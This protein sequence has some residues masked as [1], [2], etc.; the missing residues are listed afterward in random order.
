M[1]INA[2][3]S[4]QTMSTPA[5]STV[6]PSAPVPEKNSVSASEKGVQVNISAQAHALAQ[7]ESSALQSKSAQIQ[8]VPL[9]EE[10]APLPEPP[11]S[12]LTGEKLEQ[13]AQ[14]KKAQAQ[15]Q[16]QAD[17]ANMMLG[18]DTSISASTAYYL[19][20][21]EDA[22]EALL[23]SNKQQNATDNMQNYQQTVN[24]VNDQYAV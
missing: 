6:A 13:A 4:V 15:Y 5:V 14:F 16:V 17:M 10:P 2:Y 3:Q 1:Q 19:S 8:P 11:S 20:E 22:R 12:P 21:N 9:P 24:D 7:N 18:N 23:Q